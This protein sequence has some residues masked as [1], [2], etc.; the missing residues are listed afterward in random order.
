[1]TYTPATRQSGKTQ[2]IYRGHTGP[3]T[4]LDFYAVPLGGGKTRQVLISG[5]WDKSFRVWDIQVRSPDP[6]MFFQDPCPLA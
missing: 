4:S 5:S 2:Q 3:V 6:G 1:M